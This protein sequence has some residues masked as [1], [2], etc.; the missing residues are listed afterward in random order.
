MGSQT[1]LCPWYF[2]FS[3]LCLELF[4]GCTCCRCRLWTL[5][6]FS[7]IQ[8]PSPLSLDKRPHTHA[9][10]HAHT[11]ACTHAFTHT[12]THTH[13]QTHTHTHTHTHACTHVRTHACTHAHMHAR[14][15]M[16]TCAGWRMNGGMTC[17]EARGERG[18]TS[19]SVGA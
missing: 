5:L 12:I 6:R 10:T 8:N 13:T 16:R 17:Q 4:R 14:S 3:A 9:R 7:V 19:V 11:H 18:K 2:C 15:P 1:S